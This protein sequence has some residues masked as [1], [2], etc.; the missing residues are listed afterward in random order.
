MTDTKAKIKDIVRKIRITKVVATRSI[1]GRDGD[2]FA[3]FSAAWDSVQ[4]DYGGPGADLQT[5]TAEDHEAVAQG[6]TM[7]EAVVALHLVQM[8]VAI[9]ALDG[10]Y[11]SGSLGAQQYKDQKESVKSRFSA[12]IMAASERLDRNAQS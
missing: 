11:A 4:N 9:A 12:L 10:A 5:D 3:G 1:K 8:Q 7:Q 2:S 6:M